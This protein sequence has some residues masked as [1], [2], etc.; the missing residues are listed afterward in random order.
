MSDLADRAGISRATLYRDAGLR[1]LVGAAGDG[2]VVRPV[3][4]RDYERLRKRVD[5]LSAERRQLRRDLRQAEERAKAAEVHAR[6]SADRAT[7]EDVKA[8]SGSEDKARKEAYAE[9]FAAGRAAAARGGLRSGGMNDLHA[10]A[11]RLPR[12]S[13]LNAR[14][15]LARVL[16]PD[17]FAQ[18]PAAALLATE[19]LKQLNALTGPPR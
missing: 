14:R 16:H 4:A 18:D 8:P 2:P 17:L 12:Q 6:A 10:V 3:D 9:G 1:D 7:K 5:A 15:S 13:L 11:A 19:L